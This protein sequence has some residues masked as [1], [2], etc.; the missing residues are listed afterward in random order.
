MPGL[1]AAVAD[2]R[3]SE[4]PPDAQ[5]ELAQQYEPSMADLPE[6]AQDSVLTRMAPDPYRFNE[7]RYGLPENSLKA[8]QEQ[9]NEGLD[10]NATSKTGVRG[11]MQIT[12]PTAQQYGLPEELHM[13]PAAQITTAGKILGHHY[14]ET[15][16]LAKAYA[17]YGD[18]KQTG[19]ADEVMKRY[20]RMGG[21]PA[22]QATP[23]EEM[24]PPFPGYGTV[25]SALEGW[26]GNPLMRAS[27][28]TPEEKPFIPQPGLIG[29][30][31]EVLHG[32]SETLPT[33]AAGYLGSKIGGALGSV[34][35]PGGRVGGT[36]L[37]GAGGFG[38]PAGIQE[39]QRQQAAG[40]PY[41]LGKILRAAGPDALVGAATAGTGD[42][43]EQA[44]TSAAAR[45]A[46]K[47]GGAGAW[48]RLLAAIGSRT[49]PREAATAAAEATTATAGGEVERAAQTGEAPSLEDVQKRALQNALAFGAFRAMGVPFRRNAVAEEVARRQAA[50][51]PPPDIKPEQEG[52]TD[53]GKGEDIKPED[54][55]EKEMG[56]DQTEDKKPI[57]QQEQEDEDALRNAKNI[58]PNPPVTG[59]PAVTGGPVIRGAPPPPAPGEPP[60][61]VETPPAPGGGQMVEPAPEGPVAPS[62]GQG[63]ALPEELQAV[64]NGQARAYL[65]PSEGE[66][67]VPTPGE[68]ALAGQDLKGLAAGQGAGHYQGKDGSQVIYD[69]RQVT[70]KALRDLDAQ[71][72]LPEV[73]NGP[74]TAPKPD[75]PTTAVTVRT[76]SGAEARTVLT[77][78]PEQT[79]AAIA[80]QPPGHTTEVRPAAQAIPNV[81]RERGATMA[82]RT[83]DGQVYS[84]PAA[85][86]H[87]EVIER[88]G[89][90]PDEVAD[91]GFLVGGKYQA[92]NPVFSPEGKIMGTRP[93]T[94]PPDW[95]GKPAGWGDPAQQAMGRLRAAVGAP[96][97][98][99]FDI[100]PPIPPEK[101][102]PNRVATGFDPS[103][104]LGSARYLLRDKTWEPTPLLTR[105]QRTALEQSPGGAQ[106]IARYEN[107]MFRRNNW[108]QPLFLLSDTAEDVLP[109]ER[110]AFYKGEAKRL[111]AAATAAGT[112]EGKPMPPEL[113]NQLRQTVAGFE[114]EATAAETKPAPAE[115]QPAPARDIKPRAPGPTRAQKI[116]LAQLA[117]AD[118]A[119][120]QGVNKAGE[121]LSAD[122][123]ESAR[124]EAQRL[125]AR[126]QEV[127]VTPPPPPEPSELAGAVQRLRDRVQTIRGEEPP[128]EVPR[129]PEEALRR[130]R[131]GT[132]GERGSISFRPKAPPPDY[133]IK[134]EK[135]AST[136]ERTKTPDMPWHERAM[137]PVHKVQEEFTNFEYLLR[138]DPLVKEMVRRTLTNAYPREVQRAAQ[139]VSTYLG[140]MQKP[141]GEP[142]ANLVLMNDAIARREKGLAENLA[143]NPDQKGN[144]TTEPTNAEPNDMFVGV[145]TDELRANRDDLLRRVPQEVRNA[146]DRRDKVWQGIGE[147]L[148]RRGEMNPA[149]L[150]EHYF[151]HVVQDYV[152]ARSL[153]GGFPGALR[154]P[155]TPWTKQAEGSV[156]AI[157]KDVIA[158]DTKRLTQIGIAHTID[159]F[160]D[161]VL[162]MRDIL[163]TMPEE[164]RV[165]LFG[166]KPDGTPGSPVAHR[167]EF[168]VDGKPYQSYQYRRGFQYFP[169]ETE[170][171]Y[172]ATAPFDREHEPFY[173]IPKNLAERLDQGIHGPEQSQ[174]MRAVGHYVS[175]QKS[176]VLALLGLRYREKHLFGELVEMALNSPA[177]AAAV[178]NPSYAREAMAHLRGGKGAKYPD[179]QKLIEESDVLRSSFIGAMSGTGA[180]PDA[181]ARFSDRNAIL[182]AKDAVMGPVQRAIQTAEMYP[183]MIQM[184]RDYERLITGRPIKSR[185]VDLRGLPEEMKLGKKGREQT[186]DY[187][188]I[189]GRYYN[190]AVRKY[191]APWS[192]W[193]M[194][195][196][197]RM[198]YYLRHAPINALTKFGML[199]GLTYLWNN[200]VTPDVERH[201][202]AMGHLA[203]IL[204]VNLP[205]KSQAGEDLTVALHV[206]SDVLPQLIGAD[207]I[208]PAA[209]AYERGEITKEQALQQ[210]LQHM[211]GHGD[212]TKFPES[213]W[214]LRQVPLAKMFASLWANRDATTGVPIVPE[215]LKG[216][217]AETRL[218][219]YYVYQT[220]AP[221]LGVYDAAVQ[222][223]QGMETGVP[224]LPTTIGRAWHGDI[225]IDKALKDIGWRLLSTAESG[226]GSLEGAIQLHRIDPA[227]ADIQ[228][229]RHEAEALRGPKN[230][231]M[232]DL[233]DAYVESKTV[234]KPE[235]FEQARQEAMQRIRTGQAPQLGQNDLRNRIKSP[236]VQ[237]RVAQ[238][239]LENA[240]TDA[241]RH[242]FHE[243]ARYWRAKQAY[244][245]LLHEPKALRGSAYMQS[246]DETRKRMANLIR[247]M[248]KTYKDAGP[249]RPT[250][251]T[252][253]EETPE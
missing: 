211:K 148:V 141:E 194:W 156:R 107:S 85:R 30:G 49:I 71:G 155:A 29:K 12:G 235:L 172:I 218:Q 192:A 47:E 93:M 219:A 60:V 157:A 224:S 13:D 139:K 230:Q 87:A 40:E 163:H 202:Q 62:T 14:G 103:D 88:H 72:K 150:K 195:S 228:Q 187:S 119:A 6:V 221:V 253:D 117:D 166:R 94:P 140:K 225:P 99:G 174:L 233:E 138:D 226:P 243:M 200:K 38:A 170:T 165:E 162:P 130:M 232:M 53:L 77:Q 95:V 146:L 97:G 45:Q 106:Q 124:A 204:H 176:G 92:G 41:D 78:T 178:F 246:P 115:T 177:D 8:L 229:L 127:G 15:G 144:P 111:D 169:P 137:W 3:F 227:L 185:V 182:R 50:G 18:P 131:G 56:D 74:G 101:T 145:S 223:A 58:T 217:D 201:L 31:E 121:P 247:T 34:L 142:F 23:G 114:R 86:H 37:G 10:P 152:R 220:I 46:L 113:V 239:Q 32:A 90:E 100:P 35:G 251:D 96:Q 44:L 70:E 128:P 222:R 11:L 112:F 199:Y 240:D 231:T 109:P 39:Y 181:I 248:T 104:P 108:Q 16:D 48:E 22:A 110:A 20:T 51:V 245:A 26:R 84:D 191:L 215:K 143:G 116:T 80:A 89:V 64:F 180:I 102:G 186:I 122:M 213:D 17:R 2:P 21:A 238:S 63:E 179:L 149:D 198:A 252:G 118:R 33:V 190:S 193:Y 164:Q 161:K 73:V 151:P 126:L 184:I 57:W 133:S 175:G 81:L 76:P 25:G 210:V 52:P 79:D 136:L 212:L 216:T 237:M 188:A 236:D 68:R 82:V 183:H 197:S 135:L 132:P 160:M 209:G 123:R 28:F 242:Q 1:R 205:F 249:E 105:E 203:G 5:R 173:L 19:Y 234:G 147:E 24:G 9:E 7:Q 158:V 167:V 27:G 250:A 54:L 196:S 153:A 66:G 75:Q 214:L 120:T 207:Q 83:R 129:T 59:L 36:L 69:P 67:T 4:L 55:Q 42:I 43:A 159:D 91:T 208:M 241:A 98:E 134:N 206:Q 189:G 154:E 244:D 168:T 171:E 61:P 65:H 125:R